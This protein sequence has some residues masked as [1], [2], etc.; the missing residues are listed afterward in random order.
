MRLKIT[1]WQSDQITL[2]QLRREVFIQEQGVSESDELDGLDETAIHFLLFDNHQQAIGC[3]RLLLE[4]SGEQTL[5]HI[6]RVAISKAFR[7]HGLGQVLMRGTMAHCQ[8]LNPN[9]ALYLHAQTER[10]RF[11]ENLGF[12]AEGEEF[13][14]AGIPH[15]AM[16]LPQPTP[17]A[18][19]T[20]T[21]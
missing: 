11:Y 13:M 16:H 19:S 5:F 17:A 20:A 21:P 14:D 3:A 12:V 7:G 15:I 4:Q 8:Q 6:G 9:A 18:Q 10:R 2:E 1:N